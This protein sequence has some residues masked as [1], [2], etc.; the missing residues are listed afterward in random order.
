VDRVPRSRDRLIGDVP[1]LVRPNELHSRSISAPR[2]RRLRRKAPLV[3]VLLKGVSLLRC[4]CSE[5][6]SSSS[7][8]FAILVVVIG[9]LARFARPYIMKSAGVPDGVPSM[10]GAETPHFA[11][12]E[13][14][15]MATVF[16]SALR[17]FTG[18]AKREEL[19]GELS[20]KLYA[21]RGGSATMS[22][23]GIELEKPGAKP[24]GPAASPKTTADSAAPLQHQARRRRG[25]TRHPQRNRAHR[26]AISPRRTPPTRSAPLSS[27]G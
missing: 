9:A 25:P 16:K 26:H 21:N 12:E 23:L 13:S 3:R 17:L 19:A 14:D 1:L 7:L 11:S 8:P 10:A 6:Y 22:E 27:A 2:L 5:N 4:V 20:D 18:S 24:S 15:L